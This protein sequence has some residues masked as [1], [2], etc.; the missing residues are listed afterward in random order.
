L[1]GLR[2]ISSRK[3]LPERDFIAQANSIHF[4]SPQMTNIFSEAETAEATRDKD[5]ETIL[6]WLRG[7]KVQK[8][9]TI[10]CCCLFAVENKGKN[11]IYGYI[12]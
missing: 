9:G 6:I 10:H 3:Q 7:F 4:I 2:F 5:L 12:T 8:Y 1:S 11:E